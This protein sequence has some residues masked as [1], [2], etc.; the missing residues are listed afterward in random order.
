MDVLPVYIRFYV[1][2]ILLY[3]WYR[4]ILRF[5]SEIKSRKN[6]PEYN[7][8]TSIIVPVYNEKKYLLELCAESLVKAYGNNEIIFIDDCST[9]DSL[10]TLRTLKKKYPEIII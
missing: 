6:Y 10:N 9:N 3:L 2:L 5:I 4:F 7:A 1:F 8:K